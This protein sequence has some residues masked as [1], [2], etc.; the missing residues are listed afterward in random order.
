MLSPHERP[1]HHVPL[2]W[3]LS[4]RGNLDA[5][6]LTCQCHSALDGHTDCAEQKRNIRA[7]YSHVSV[8]SFWLPVSF[9]G[10]CRRPGAPLTGP[11]KVRV[12]PCAVGPSTIVTLPIRLPLHLRTPGQPSLQMGVREH[13][14][15]AAEAQQGLCCGLSAKPSQNRQLCSSAHC[16]NVCKGVVQGCWH[17][18]H[19]A[20]A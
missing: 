18:T 2:A 7:A 13:F 5:Q 10:R 16:G 14:S 4:A 12:G 17:Y 6:L 9:S 15:C 8:F 19:V 11:P 3:P 1:F 20:A